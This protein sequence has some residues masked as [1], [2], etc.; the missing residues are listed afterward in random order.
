MP[1]YYKF[2]SKNYDHFVDRKRFNRIITEYN[3]GI[4][5]LMI[6]SNMDYT[7][8]HLLYELNIRKVKRKP[9][10]VDGKLINNIPIDWKKTNK[11]WDEDP[12][13]KE[14][15][16]L[17]RYD[18]THTSGFVYKIY[19]KKFKANVKHKTFF[20]FLPTRFFK[21][22]LSKRIKDINKDNFDSFLLHK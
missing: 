17:V 21:R 8:P 1:D 22:S 3:K 5:D 14:L 11:L 15:K 6:N 2:Y 12:E 18:N 10:I 19:M 7:I 4:I 13:A 20:K 16:L 9:R